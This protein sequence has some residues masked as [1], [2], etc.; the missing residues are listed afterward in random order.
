MEVKKLVL[1]AASGPTTQNIEYERT[2][3]IPRLLVQ[4]PKHRQSCP[5]ISGHADIMGYQKR[6][7][8]DCFWSLVSRSRPGMLLNSDGVSCSSPITKNCPSQHVSITQLKTP[9]LVQF[10]DFK[11]EKLSPETM[12]VLLLNSLR[13]VISALSLITKHSIST[14][15]VTM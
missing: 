14:A 3:D 12:F 4:W 15:G 6:G 11:Y 10:P 5:G 2:I 8:G 13:Q 1:L 9:A 7:A